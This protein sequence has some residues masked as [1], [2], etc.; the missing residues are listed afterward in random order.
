M[1]PGELAQTFTRDQGLPFSPSFQE[2]TKIESD[3]L[4]AGS[5]PRLSRTLMVTLISETYAA[6]KAELVAGFSPALCLKQP[7]AAG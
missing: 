3:K 6:G 5:M 2:A 1:G 4:F 7:L